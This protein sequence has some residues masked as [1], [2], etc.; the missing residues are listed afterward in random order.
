MSENARTGKI[1][2]LPAPVRQEVNL[3]LYNGEGSPQILPWLHS[4][5]EVLQILD[6]RWA[7]QPITAQNLSEWRQG[8]YKDWL[9]R[10][11]RVDQIK[12]LS[13]YS[14]QLARAGGGAM[15]DGAV[16]IL[17]GRILEA[18]EKAA[19]E[20]VEGEP[21]VDL[22]GLAK[23]LVKLRKSDLDARS[24]DQRDRALEHRERT[25]AL[26]EQQFQAKTCE[27]FLKWF[28]DKRAVQI[29]ESSGSN[30]VKIEELRK[31]FFGDDDEFF[32]EP[33][34]KDE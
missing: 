28:N 4:L 32:P 11:D 20:K 1:A 30:Q 26:A 31:A 18:L 16:A 33:L 23:C 12:E 21:S 24:L 14:A 9:R 3:R 15:S 10:R 8:G 34:N 7:E 6:D 19:D 25:V 29:A 5:P 2:S 13:Q 27:L 17:G 22:E